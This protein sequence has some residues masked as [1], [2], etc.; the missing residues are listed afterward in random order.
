MLDLKPLAI[1]NNIELQ[2]EIRVDKGTTIF[3]DSKRIEQ[4]FSNLIKNS[5]DFV[6]ENIGKIMIKARESIDNE[7]VS[8]FSSR[9]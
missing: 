6:S 5:I 8:L 3:C 1:E 9:R 2:S 7:S 4:V